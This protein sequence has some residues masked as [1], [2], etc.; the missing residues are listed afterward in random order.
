[1]FRTLFKPS[2][3]FVSL[4]GLYKLRVYRKWWG[5]H[6]ELWRVDFPVC[7][8][9]WHDVEE[10]SLETKIRPYGLLRGV[11]VCEQHENTNKGF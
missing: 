7:S 3:L 5:G 4:L 9:I 6:W 10:C 8:E 2:S 11:P 1:M